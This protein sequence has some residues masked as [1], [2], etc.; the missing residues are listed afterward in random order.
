MLQITKKICVASLILIPSISIISPTKVSAQEIPDFVEQAGGNFIDDILGDIGGIA[1]EFLEDQSGF[2]SEAIALLNEVFDINIEEGR[3]RLENLGTILGDLPLEENCSSI[4]HI[5]P[6]ICPDG[7]EGLELPE[8][9]ETEDDGEVRASGGLRSNSQPQQDALSSNRTVL[10]RD[11]ANLHDRQTS[12]AFAFDYL[13]ETGDEWL[14]T[15]AA[16][17]QA[18][19]EGSDLI[20]SDILELATDAQDLEVTQDVMKNMAGMNQLRSQIDINNGILLG[21]INTSLLNIQQQNAS[22][23]MLS[24]NISEAF[25]ENN[26]ARRNE[27]DIATLESFRNSIFIPGLIDNN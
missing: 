13:G 4:L 7:V 2:F 19:L 23:L 10:E 24:A 27:Q 22:Q 17:N 25:D 8:V 16:E 20:Q 5:V 18:L 14:L 9:V 26:R 12:R 3:F 1:E 6:G 15:N 21:R 11:L